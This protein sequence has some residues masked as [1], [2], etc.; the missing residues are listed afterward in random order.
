M[1]SE[2][3]TLLKNP[4]NNEN[5]E[6]ISELEENNEIKKGYLKSDKYSFPIQNGVINFLDPNDEYINKEMTHNYNTKEELIKKLGL[7]KFNEF[8]KNQILGLDAPDYYDIYTRSTMNEILGNLKLEDS[9]ILEIGGST[10]RDLVNYFGYESN[11]C[12]ELDINPFLDEA[13]EIIMTE[14]KYYYERIRASMTLLPFKNETIDFIF[15]S[16]T[17]H[18]ID[19]PAECFKEVYRVLKPGGKF[20]ILNERTLSELKPSLKEMIS[21]ELEYAHEHA[22]FWNEWENFLKESGFT[23]KSFRPSYFSYP[24]IIERTYGK[25]KPK[26]KLGWIR[27]FYYKTMSFMILKQSNK[28]LKIF[29][30]IENKFFGNV[31]FNAMATK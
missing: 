25:E 21:K 4:L 30:K 14:K 15:G 11:L 12:I 2:I 20:C 23:V 17:F 6:L 27:Y 24:V 7:Q 31:P 29:Q 3:L 1:K 5:L 10:G 19:N 13:S 26:N 8:K 18:H 16:A 28:I 22:F 9:I